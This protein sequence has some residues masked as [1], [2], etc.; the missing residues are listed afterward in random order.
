MP[1]PRKPHIGEPFRLRT[2][3]TL[4]LIAPDGKTVHQHRRRLALLV[5]IAASGKTGISRDKLIA[6]LSPES[7][8]ESAR[9]GLNQLL[10]VIRGQIAEDIV[11]GSDP[12]ALNPDVITSD[13][14]DLSDAIA[15]KSHQRTVEL[16]RG[17]FL[18]GFHL[19]GSSEFDNWADAERQRLRGEYANALSVLATNAAERRDHSGAVKWWRSL[20]ALDP[21][22]GRAALGLM[23]A[24]AAAGDAPSALVYARQHKDLVRSE[25]DA[26][27]DAEVTA[28]SEMLKTR[29]IQPSREAASVSSEFVSQSSHE[30]QPSREAAS[31][32][33]EFVSQASHA[34]QPA[35]EA[36]AKVRS[37][38]LAWVT[39]TAFVIA[40][41]G[42]ALLQ[43]ASSESSSVPARFTPGDQI[44]VG[45]FTVEPR[46]SLSARALS[47]V[48]RTSLTESRAITVVSR[49]E[50]DRAL[51]RMQL[52]ITSPLD[53]RLARDVATRNGYEVVLTGGIT[54]LAGGY[55]VSAHLVATNGK[56]IALLSET[57]PT[58]NELIPAVGRMSKNL[59]KHM[60][61]RAATIDSVKPLADVTTKSLHALQLFTQAVDETREGRGQ[62]P[63]TITLLREAVTEDS[64]FAMAH[65]LLGIKLYLLG[66]TGEAIHQLRMAERFSGHFTER[67]RLQSLS[68]LHLVLRDYSKSADEASRVLALRPRSLWAL[69]QLGIIDN[70]LGR[71]EH[72]K[73][74]AALRAKLD[75]T[76]DSDLPPAAI[77]S[78]RQ[79]EAVALGRQRIERFRNAHHASAAFIGARLSMAAIFS[80]TAAFDSAA[81]YAAP[82]GETYPGDRD[83]LAHSLLAGGRMTEA[84]AAMGVRARGNDRVRASTGFDAMHEA[85]AASALAILAGDAAAASRRLDAVT[86]DTTYRAMP[87]G[88]RPIGLVLALA[89]AGRPADA[90]REL[91]AIE[92]GSDA[93]LVKARE[94]ELW[95]ARGAVALATH[96]IPEAIDAFSRA[97]SSVMISYDACRVCSLPWLGRAYEAAGTPDSAVAVYDRFLST[98]DH[99]RIYADGIWRAYVLRRLGTLHSGRGDTAQ[100]LDRFGQFIALWRNS[101]PELQAQVATARRQIAE[102]RR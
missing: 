38:R 58:K 97:G 17:A 41:V 99:D 53:D 68:T 16:Y 93:D 71:Y 44:L 39:G 84:F 94:P 81:L 78:N 80:A 25:L 88:D 74:I 65:R 85:T 90:R 91:K 6:W 13:L 87:P 43:G 46:D 28:F 11:L 36:P 47:E 77:R 62:E 92:R 15:S 29:Q 8:T 56:E 18:D 42:Y 14:S 26:V 5:L 48:L 21:L 70:L 51:E 102:L 27:P 12:I 57:A 32:S 31:V 64:T 40:I 24:L 63:R 75:P 69:N 37:S 3:G 22:S 49:A 2:L 76:G 52:P 23:R 61:E 34:D 101:D 9:H 86:I 96:R 1:S 4:L 30:G 66:S 72:A 45:D 50:V 89:L 100:A 95:M 10:Y 54:P 33:S 55:I 79:S 7:T 83:I 67:E 19:S 20:A 59:R 98:G 60:G 82:D 73:T 35:L